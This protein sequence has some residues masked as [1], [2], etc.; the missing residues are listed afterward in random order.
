MS[1]QIQYYFPCEG[2]SSENFTTL[3]EVKDR[4]KANNRWYYDKSYENLTILEVV[5]EI[6][7]YNLMK[8]G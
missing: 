4:I 5:R 2:I 6:D 7:V 8:D 1:Y 3:K